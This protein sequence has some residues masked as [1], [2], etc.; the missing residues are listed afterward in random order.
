M[1]RVGFL[2]E[3]RATLSVIFGWVPHDAGH[4]WAVA[5]NLELRGSASNSSNGKTL[6]SREPAVIRFVKSVM[7]ESTKPADGGASQ[8]CSITLYQTDLDNSG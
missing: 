3:T 6:Y 5:R 8:K 7:V 2:K 1:M 4:R